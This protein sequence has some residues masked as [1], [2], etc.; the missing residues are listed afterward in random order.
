M[1]E[2]KR[3][4]SQRLYDE[5]MKGSFILVNKK[6]SFVQGKAKSPSKTRTWTRKG[7]KQS[8]ERM[9]PAD[10]QEDQDPLPPQLPPPREEDLYAAEIFRSIVPV[11]PTAW[12]MPDWKDGK[13]SVSFL[14]SPFLP[15][16]LPPFFMAQPL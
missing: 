7:A 10:S 6:G 3:R 2:E 13:L 8:K 4:E 16:S 12:C 5:L 1:A 11:S 9:L 15:S 14:L